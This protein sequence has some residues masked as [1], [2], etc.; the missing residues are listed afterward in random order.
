MLSCH[1]FFKFFMKNPLLS[2]PYMVKKTLNLSKLHYFG[3]KK[4]I[5]CPSFPIFHGKIIALISSA[6]FLSR[7]RPFS[8]DHLFLCPYYVKKTSILTKTN[9]S[10]I[11]FIKFFIKNSLCSCPYLV[12]KTSILSNFTHYDQKNE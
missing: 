7:N 11:I 6:H 5:G 3:P 4:T 9:C 1:F 8:K 2:S 10:H 12:K